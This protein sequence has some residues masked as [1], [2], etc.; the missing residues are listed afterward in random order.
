[1]AG[2]DSE[3]AVLLAELERAL[4]ERQETILAKAR[5]NQQLKRFVF[6]FYI[7]SILF[8]NFVSKLF[9]HKLWHQMKHMLKKL[10]FLQD[11]QTPV[12]Q[13]LIN[14]IFF[15]LQLVLFLFDINL[16]HVVYSYSLSKI[17]FHLFEI[18]KQIFLILSNTYLPL[19]FY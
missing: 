7:Y 10:I 15:L 5:T 9:Q 18:V 6:S 3:K 4:N 16:F 14:N 11:Q 13:N 1:V 2:L 19:T 8:C 17:F 12:H